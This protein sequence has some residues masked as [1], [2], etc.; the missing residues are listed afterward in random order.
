MHAYIPD[1]Y[2]GAGQGQTYWCPHTAAVRVSSHVEL[3]FTVERPGHEVP[4]GQILGVVDLNSRIPLERRG[5]DVVVIADAKY[6]WVGVEPGQYGVEHQRHLV[7]NW[8]AESGMET[9]LEVVPYVG[10]RRGRAEVTL[11][12]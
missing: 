11:E 2:R 1:G 7:K 3:A 5:R 8:A 6:G 10:S 4:V 9:S 12:R